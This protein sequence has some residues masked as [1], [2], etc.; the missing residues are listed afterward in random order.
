LLY[1]GKGRSTG[2]S[3]IFDQFHWPTGLGHRSAF[4]T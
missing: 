1:V 4:G 3:L 2:P